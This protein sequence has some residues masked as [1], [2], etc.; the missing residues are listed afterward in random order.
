MILHIFGGILWRNIML[1]FSNTNLALPAMEPASPNQSVTRKVDKRVAT[2]LQ[3][4]VFIIELTNRL[5]L[6]C[7]HL[8]FKLC[9][10]T[11]QAWHVFWISFTFFSFGVC[12]VF[13]FTTSG[14]IIN[15]NNTYIQVLLYVIY[16]FSDKVKSSILIS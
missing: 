2:V 12:C 13:I 15:Q 6:F 4:K 5:S 3:G 10:S 8:S 16:T 9:L 1:K 7:Q 11:L 14:S